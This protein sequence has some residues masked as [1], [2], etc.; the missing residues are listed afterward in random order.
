MTGKAVMDTLLAASRR[1][2]KGKN[3][4]RKANYKKGM[5]RQRLVRLTLLELAAVTKLCPPVRRPPHGGGNACG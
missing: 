4:R 5:V 1:N 2:E 3:S